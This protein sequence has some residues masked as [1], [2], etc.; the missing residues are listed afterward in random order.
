MAIKAKHKIEAGSAIPAFVSGVK[1]GFLVKDTDTIVD[2]VYWQVKYINADK[3]KISATVVGS[4]NDK[5][6]EL[7]YKNIQIPANLEGDNFIKQVYLHMK[8]L[9]E[10]ADAI[11]C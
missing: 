1:G 5:Q 8:T 3:E 4:L 6:D 11:D 9:P 7:A 10:F 2:G